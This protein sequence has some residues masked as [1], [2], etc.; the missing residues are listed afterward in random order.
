MVANAQMVTKIPIVDNTH[1]QY[2]MFVHV[3]NYLCV[4]EHL[5][6]MLMALHKFTQL[7]AVW[8]SVKMDGKFDL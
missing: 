8:T 3:G 2:Q 6:W 4:G 1:E 7:Q 5:F